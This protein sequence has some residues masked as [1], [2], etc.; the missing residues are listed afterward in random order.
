MH[1]ARSAFQ[2]KRGAALRIQAAYRGHT[3]RAVAADR[4]QHRA[5]LQIQAAWRGRV[6]RRKFLATRRSVV[7]LQVPRSTFAPHTR[8]M[9]P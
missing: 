6:A 8:L 9:P 1:I 5:A 4:R 7:A 2:R 3:A